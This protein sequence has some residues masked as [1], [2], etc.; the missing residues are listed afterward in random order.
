[1]LEDAFEA[2][3]VAELIPG[4]LHNFANPLNGI[5][6]RAQILQRRLTDTIKK[7]QDQYPDA[8]ATFSEPYKKLVTDVESICR[9]SDR[10]YNM[11]QDVSGR[12]Y[13]IGSIAPQRIDIPFLLSSELRF[14]DYYLDFKHEV[15]K[16]CDLEESLS[17]VYGIASYYS[18]CFWSLFRN[19]MVRM[20]TVAEKVI[21]ISAKQENKYVIVIIRHP[22]TPLTEEE[23]RMIEQ[24]M[25]NNEDTA[26]SVLLAN[27]FYLSLC[28]LKEM[29]ALVDFRQQDGFHEIRIKCPC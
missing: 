4:I 21:H 22:G 2:T 8:A 13:A 10:F 18:L 16:E 12:F 24:I 26:V 9:E 15:R 23:N 28:L 17:E 1:M 29:G 7:I 25:S 6:G 5:M 27:E 11:F 20:K 19:A 3:F 14:A